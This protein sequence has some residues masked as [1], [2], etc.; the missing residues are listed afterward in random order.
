MPY[1]G[2]KQAAALHAKYSDEKASRVIHQLKK[3]PKK[4]PRRKKK[5]D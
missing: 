5:S 1:H 2:P 4:K 3:H